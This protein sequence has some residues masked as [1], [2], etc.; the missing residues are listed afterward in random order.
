MENPLTGE[1]GELTRG[2][3]SAGHLFVAFFASEVKLQG[4]FG[5]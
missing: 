4:N 5:Q 1:E 3:G 2:L